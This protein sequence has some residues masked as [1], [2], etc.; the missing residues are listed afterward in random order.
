MITET[1]S[2]N[3]SHYNYT[4]HNCIKDWLHSYT[5]LIKDSPGLGKSE[6]IQLQKNYTGFPVVHFNSAKCTVYLQLKVMQLFLWL[7]VTQKL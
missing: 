1:S 2:N 4:V 6:Q 5:T 7:V 3:H